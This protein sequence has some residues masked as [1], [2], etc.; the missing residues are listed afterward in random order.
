VRRRE[1]KHTPM[2]WLRRPITDST[3]AGLEPLS[4]I[5]FKLCSSGFIYIPSSVSVFLSF[6]SSRHD[7]LSTDAGP[8]LY[9]CS[10]QK[11]TRCAQ[12]LL[13]RVSWSLANDHQTP[14]CQG[15]RGPKL[16]LLLCLGRQRPPCHHWHRHRTLH[17]GPTLVRFS[18]T[19]CTSTLPICHKHRS[20]S[21]PGIFILLREVGASEG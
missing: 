13:R 18:C 19:R 5:R 1:R 9:K 4:W 10:H 20:R 7:S 16:W 12:D 17:R 15:A 8:L 21:F 14:R 2:R 6:P 11:H 3:W